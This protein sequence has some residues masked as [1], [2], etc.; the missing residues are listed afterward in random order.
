MLKA[1]RHI[2]CECS[3]SLLTLRY[4]KFILLCCEH[5][6]DKLLYYTETF[7]HSKLVVS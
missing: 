7:N 5:N 4:F 6:R 1:L 2:K 3:S